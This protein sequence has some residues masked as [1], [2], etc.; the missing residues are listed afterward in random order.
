MGDI[1]E[2]FSL[3]EFRCRDDC[4]LQSLDCSLVERLQ[5]L[6]DLVRLPII[7][8]SGCRCER[9]NAEVG[10]AINSR[11]LAIPGNNFLPDAADFTI[12]EHQKLYWLDNMFYESW[13]GGWKYYIEKNIIHCDLGPYRRW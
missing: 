4:G 13:S 6:R 5:V 9:H 8:T 3:R 7:I 10:G 2:N 1:T 12:A 11:H